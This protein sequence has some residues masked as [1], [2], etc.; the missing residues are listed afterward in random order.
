M[1]RFEKLSQEERNELT[2]A[3]HVLSTALDADRPDIWFSEQFVIK[4]QETVKKYEG[5]Q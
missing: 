1:T 3:F 2:N 5:E 4:A